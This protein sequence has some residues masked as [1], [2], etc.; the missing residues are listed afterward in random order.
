MKLWKRVKENHALMMLI[1]C[2]IPIAGILVA[3]YFFNFNPPYLIWI[4][5]LICILSH[6]FMMKDMHSGKYGDNKK[7]KRG[8]CH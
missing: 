4:A 2:G 3:R 7:S 1:C 8:G 6:Y 5:L